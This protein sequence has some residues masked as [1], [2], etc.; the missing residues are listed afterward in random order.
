MKIDLEQI[1]SLLEVVGP[2]DITE[3]TIESGEEKITIKKQQTVIAS[4][5]EMPMLGR[6]APQSAQ[7]PTP[8]PEASIATKPAEE[9]NNGNKGLVP[10]T[11]PMVGTFY[12]SPS[13]TAPAFVDVGDHVAPGQTVCII[14]A[15]K[16]MNDMPAEVSG[17]IVKVCVENGS[18]V[19]YGQAL[20]M[21]NP[22]G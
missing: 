9:E 14:E 6:P 12:R 13:P 2:T 1:K 4:T 19:E 7:V 20:F 16:L 17:K 11:S 10:I 21:V 18:T 5:V 3:L 15:M 22:K 8:M